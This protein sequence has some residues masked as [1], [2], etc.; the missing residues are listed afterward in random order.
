MGSWCWTTI[1]VIV[2]LGCLVQSAQRCH[3]RR[4]CG[5]PRGFAPGAQS[6]GD[7]DE[8]NLAM[9]DGGVVLN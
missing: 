9:Q 5:L 8:M 3:R 4:L 6:D 7:G 1:A 2:K